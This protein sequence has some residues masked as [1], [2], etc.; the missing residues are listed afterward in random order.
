MAKSDSKPAR[1]ML[2]MPDL[3]HEHEAVGNGARIVA[4]IDE[5]GRGPLAGPVVAAAV[6]LDPDNIPPGLNDSKKLNEERREALFEQIITS[7]QVGFCAAPVEVIDRLNILGATLWA[8]CH[9][10]DALPVRPDVAL[11]DGNHVPKGLSCRGQFVIGGDG[12]SLSIAA[13]SIVAKV[14]RDRMCK[15]MDCGHPHYSFG[16]H[17]GYGTALHL[18]ALSAHGPS[19]MHRMSFAPVL[20]ARR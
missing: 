12:K 17:K 6:V 3:F 11:I 10:L 1:Q 5:A 4:G 15:I 2:P 20:A 13:A 9:A 19:E 18:E 7:A 8:M 16:Q 14:V